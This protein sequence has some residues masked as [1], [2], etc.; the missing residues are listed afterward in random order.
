MRTKIDLTE[1]EVNKIYMLAEQRNG[2]EKRFGAKTYGGKRGSLE[3]H[4]IGLAGEYAVA[5]FFNTDINY[6]VYNNKGDNGIDI[7]TENRKMSVKTT[8]Y[9]EKPFLRVEANKINEEVNTYICVYVNKEDIKD[10]WIIGWACK[11]KVMS[12][13]KRKFSRF[14]P[15]NYVLEEGELSSIQ[16][17]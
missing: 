17:I 5:K 3:A 12:S 10:V 2:K 13:K 8:T 1:E 14:G 7:H 15:T 4:V 16:I 6:F 9:G 11:D